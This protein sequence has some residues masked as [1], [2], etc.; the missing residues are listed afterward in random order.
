MRRKRNIDV[1][2]HLLN[3]AAFIDK[4][5]F[6]VWGR[7][8]QKPNMN[9]RGARNLA[10]GGL[11]SFYARCI[12]GRSYASK[13]VFQFKYGCMRPSYSLSPFRFTIWAGRRTAV[14]SDV[15][16]ALDVLMRRGYR[17]KVSLA[18]LSFDITDIPFDELTW[19][20]V[21]VPKADGADPHRYPLKA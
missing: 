11:H 3:S 1:Y 19:E 18:E 12:R 20:A 10:I 13:N 7:K 6:E 15:L 4:A 9:I 21:R 5:E 8:R 16:L 14:Y 2:P 17:L